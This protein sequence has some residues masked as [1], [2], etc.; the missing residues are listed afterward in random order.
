MKGES[1]SILQRPKGEL[2]SACHKLTKGGGCVC[3]C[4]MSRTLRSP[5]DPWMPK[6]TIICRIINLYT[7]IKLALCVCVMC[8]F[9]YKALQ[10]LVRISILTV[11]YY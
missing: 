10:N 9:A 1:L 7:C 11:T 6:F 5:G 8:F 2:P 4:V 3:V